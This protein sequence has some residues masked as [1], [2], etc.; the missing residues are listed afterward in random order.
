VKVIIV[1][2]V[3]NGFCRAGNLASDRLAGVVEPIRRHLEEETAAGA[4]VIFV[5]DTHQPD[6]PE[7]AMFAE[8][9]VAGS[10]EDEIVDELKPFADPEFTVR[11]A[12]YS[13]FHGT[14]LHDMLERLAP[15]EV[16]V[17]GVCTDI[18]V[19]HTVADLRVR[20]YT[21]SVPVGLVETYDAPGHPAL[22]ISRFAMDHMRDILGA[23]LT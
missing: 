23:R 22:E 3:L 21:V 10:G 11:K 15:D 9:C 1:V 13:A 16:E 17:I 4:R 14:G 19:M 6:D 8:H 7:F 20:G 18:C 2:D 12:T 5:V